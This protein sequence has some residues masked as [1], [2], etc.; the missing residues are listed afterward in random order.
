MVWIRTLF[1]ELGINLGPIP[2]CGDN[3]G[4]IFLASNL[5]QE[6]HIKHIDLCYH[7]ICEVIHQKQV[8]LLFV[9]GAKNPTDLFTKNLGQIKLLKFREQLGL[10]FYEL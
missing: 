4:S 10:Q 1:K 6:K 3:Q 2:L 5:V 7:Y 9:E 8:E